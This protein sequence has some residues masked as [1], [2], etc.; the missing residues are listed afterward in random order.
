VTLLREE[1][2]P[3]KL[4]PQSDL[5]CRADAHWALPQICS[6]VYFSLCFSLNVLVMLKEKACGLK[7]V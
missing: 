6:C 1:Y 2:E 5:E 7:K 4:S 3:L